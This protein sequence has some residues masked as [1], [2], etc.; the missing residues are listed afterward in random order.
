MILAGDIGGT[1]TRL[2]C[3]E[4]AGATSTLVVEE[5]FSSQDYN[6]LGEIV[7]TFLARHKMSIRCASFGIAGPVNQQC[8][9]TPNLAW[10]VDGNELSHMLQVKT[11]GLINDLEANAL[12]IACL[13]P[14]DFCVLSEGEAASVGNAAI[15]SAGTGLGEAGLYWDG[16]QHHPFA[17]EGGHADLAPRNNKELEL[18]RFLLKQFGHVSYERVLS[19]PGILNIYQFFRLKRKKKVP[20]WIHAGMKERDPAAVISEAGVEG[21]CEICVETMDLFISLYGAEAGNL[22]LKVMARGGLYIGGG[23]APK[24]IPKLRGPQFLHSFRDKGRMKPLLE[25]IPIRVIL[26]DKAALLGAARHARL[27]IDS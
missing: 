23:I 11:V 9:R 15:I 13:R 8:V 14:E 18:L 3:F 26:N 7:K 21:T 25:E 6:S 22:A 19:G 4:A 5:T 2:A 10:T 12:G 17:S 1:N 27:Q 16:A 24:I 20:A